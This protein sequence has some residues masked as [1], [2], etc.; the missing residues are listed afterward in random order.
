MVKVPASRSPAARF[1][2][3]CSTSRVPRK[4]TQPLALLP[5]T[6]QALSD[7]LP[8]LLC[9]EASAEIVFIGAVEAL[10]ETV[11]PALRSE[12]QQIAEDEFHHGRWL[13]ALRDRLPPPAD[14]DGALRAASFLRRLQSRDLG[15]QLARVAALDAGACQIFKE[16][17]QPDAITAQQPDLARLFRRLLRDEGRHVRV[18]LRCATALGVSRERMRV[19]RREV[20]R[21]LAALLAPGTQA[22]LS[23]GV[24][25][26]RLLDHLNRAD[27]GGALR[28]K[29]GA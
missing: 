3:L 23:L 24:N 10:P 8:L 15:V 14:G 29:A 28:M 1:D 25:I 2:A 19:E 26:V 7:L 27:S 6:A 20:W 18:T 13:A 9:G 4:V 11:S 22:F 5:S 16:L 21:R 12:L 17:T